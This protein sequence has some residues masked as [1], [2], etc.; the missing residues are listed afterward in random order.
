M[1]EPSSN[2]GPTYRYY[3]E[4]CEVYL[5]APGES[6]KHPSGLGGHAVSRWYV[7]GPGAL[8]GPV[9]QEEADA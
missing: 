5:D 6:D 1:A 4:R 8:Y 9:Q 3:C 2:I 7:A